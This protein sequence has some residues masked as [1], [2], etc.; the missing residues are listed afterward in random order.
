[1]VESA[2]A[3]QAGVQW[4]DLG[5]PQLPP[6]GFNSWDYSHVPP[7]LANFVFSVVMRFLHVGQ[8]GLKLPTSGDLPT[9]A[10]QSVGITDVSHR[11]QPIFILLIFCYVQGLTLLPRLECSGVIMAH[12]NLKLLGSG[13]P[14]ASA[15]Q[16]AGT[17]GV[18]YVAQAVLKLLASSDPLVSDF[19]SACITGMSLCAWPRIIANG[20]QMS[21]HKVF[22]LTDSLLEAPQGCNPDSRVQ[23]IN[24]TSISHVAG[25]TSMCH[26]IQLIRTGF[27]H[28]GQAGLK[29]LTPSDM[30]A[31]AFQSAGII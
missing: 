13:N 20:Y 28:G 31:S 11:P 29:L 19:Q 6:P 22:K 24:P 30:P 23:A 4:H 1:M 25:I 8:A 7:R 17:T 26:R 21:L 9:L 3:A 14:P 27:H 16:G 15:S 18:Y 2:L 12:C 5:S 10:S